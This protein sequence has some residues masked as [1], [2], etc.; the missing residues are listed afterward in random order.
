ML[1]RWN[2]EEAANLDPLGQ[3]V[4]QS[5]LLGAETSLVLWGGGNTSLKVTETDFRGRETRVLRVKG[6]GSDMKT[7]E[8]KHFP[9]VRM[10]DILPLQERDAM[11]DEEMV[12]YLAHALME[13]DSPRPSI[14]TLL[15]GFVPFAGV[16]HT[17]A[18]AI[19]SLTNNTRG[20]AAVEECFG[21]KALIVDYIR[22]GFTLSKRVGQA[23]KSDST[24]R[25]LVLM[26]HG[27]IT[28]ADT[29][30]EA[31]EIHITMV[32]QA[33]EF[34]AAHAQ[35]KRVFGGVK[36]AALAEA[37]RREIAAAVAPALRGA[38]ST[39]PY[40][41]L[42]KGGVGG[43]AARR[44]ILRLDD[45]PDILDFLGS[46]EAARL[47]QI[48]PAT[49]DHLLH[50]RRTPLFL[51]VAD[52][53]DLETIKQTIREQAA[54]WATAYQ[55]YMR[56][57]HP[58]EPMPEPVPRVVLLPGIGMWTVGKDAKSARV[59][60][61]IYHH[62]I[63]V[64]AGARALGEYVSVSEKDACSAECWP[65]QLYKLTLAPPEKD[66]ARRIALVTGATGGIGKVLCERF[67]QEGAHIVVTD[68]NESA[69]VEF[70]ES[71]CS[72]YGTGMAA[73]V[74]M[75]V[76]REES[77]RE[78]YRKAVLAFGGLDILVSNAGIAHSAR[79]EELE[80]ADWQKSLNVNATGHFLV[81]REAVRLFREQGIGGNIVFNVTKNTLAAGAEFGAYSAAKAAELQLARVLAIENGA[82][83]I[84]VNMLNPDAIFSAGL[85]SPELKAKRA[86]AQGI[87]VEQVEEFY[88]QR[89]L[90]KVSVTAQDVAE[91]ALW[92]ASDRSAKTTGC[93]IPIDGGIREAF[94]R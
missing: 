49:P 23:A 12:A 60:G 24:V 75:D 57:H 6:S 11:S 52:L 55:D 42:S 44:C 67:A 85:W 21:R 17:H 91:A 92:L 30:R 72:Q 77:V 5:R 71:L 79:I 59:P 69:C 25:A 89:N 68:L 16:V 34:L 90:L 43:G 3:L 33:E 29:P 58:N 80:L 78:A 46:E 88:R 32:T 81:S 9:G 15:H 74:A 26:N 73:G 27:F 70:A 45:S 4:Y 41:P 61:D 14:E 8:R 64:M 36:T 35:G 65:M 38:L 53:S 84:R 39:P 2:Q 20:R 18:D 10:D 22:P 31:Y 82:Y 54:A 83:G 86:Q 48:G 19:V 28:W 93:I 51:N 56:D 40:P 94:P 13:P 76:T 50:T 47:S 62:T 87:P 66:L 63:S 7:I 1:N 37:L